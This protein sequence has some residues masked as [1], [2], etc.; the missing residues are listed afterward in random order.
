MI[1][2][3]IKTCQAEWDYHKK[4][5]RIL[6]DNYEGDPISCQLCDQSNLKYI[7]QVINKKTKA[8]WNIGRNCADEFGDKIKKSLKEI[9]FLHVKTLA[10]QQ[11]NEQVPGVVSYTE[12]EQR[13]FNKADTLLP[14]V[15][16]NKKQDLLTKLNNAIQKYY[17]KPHQET[18]QEIK[19]LFKDNVE[20]DHNIQSLKEKNQNDLLYPT[21]K[22]VRWL[23]KNDLLGQTISNIRNNNGLI[24]KS[25][26]YKIS[27][28]DFIK[29]LLSKINF[30]YLTILNSNQ[31]TKFI[32]FKI[33]KTGNNTILEM[34]TPEFLSV[35]TE[36]IWDEPFDEKA[37]KE[38]LLAEAKL[39]SK[40]NSH[41]S[42][43][44]Q[45]ENTFN[46]LGYEIII[47]KYDKNDLILKT[48]S[49]YLKINNGKFLQ[50]IKDIHL[51]LKPAEDISIRGIIDCSIDKEYDAT[52][53]KTY[54]DIAKN[55]ASLSKNIKEK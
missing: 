8:T 53:W 38:E 20:Q 34:N 41:A 13:N 16:H 36:Y 51:N 15:L 27:E 31:I 40:F 22:I 44:K 1:T 30:S 23:R 10:L 2:N 21:P 29:A 37:I 47:N 55:A 43:F 45:Y 18:L 35:F 17:T 54:M 7:H 19:T 25:D 48:N 50:N 39:S 33:A 4:G 24:P 32:N 9:E 3:V 49:I 6:P 14:S 5:F 11:L 28:I 12:N 46:N 42:I 26:F 52:S